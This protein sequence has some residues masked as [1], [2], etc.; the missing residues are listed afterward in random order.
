MGKSENLTSQNRGNWIEENILT[1]SRAADN[2]LDVFN[3]TVKKYASELAIAGNDSE[4][5]QYGIT[6]IKPK[7][8]MPILD[9]PVL[10]QSY[11]IAK[12]NTYSKK[13]QSWRGVVTEVHENYFKARLEDITNGGTDEMGEFD[14]IEVAPDDLEFLKK[15]GV[16]YW[17][18]GLY[19]E[20]GQIER[21][22]N[23]RFQRLILLDEEEINKTVDNVATKY[24]NLKFE[25]IDYKPTK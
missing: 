22:S 13:V 20:H 3:S 12:K 4:K 15:G 21:K 19:M 25:P 11:D 23:I 16:F 6:S 9:F 8:A 5:V 14:I 24:G 1:S 2:K 7:N 18:V 10:K 17:S